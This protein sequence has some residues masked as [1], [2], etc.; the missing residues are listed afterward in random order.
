MDRYSDFTLY[1]EDWGG[2]ADREE[3]FGLPWLVW[4]VASA[5]RAARCE[6]AQRSVS[7]GEVTWS[8]GWQRIP[9]DLV[10][11][12][13]RLLDEAGAFGNPQPLVDDAAHAPYVSVWQLTGVARGRPFHLR[14]RFTTPGERWTPL[15]R[16]LADA[17][18]ALRS[19]E[20]PRAP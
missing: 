18:H 10:D 1:W 13:P 12:L 15:G 6:V 20:P 2:Y 19:P 8:A 4:V 14:L 9:R 11:P 17:L 5:D 16:R 7:A 3:P